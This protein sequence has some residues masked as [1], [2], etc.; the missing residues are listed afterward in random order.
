M[1]FCVFSQNDLAL[2]LVVKNDLNVSFTKEIDFFAAKKN[3]PIKQRY[4]VTGRK[5]LIWGAS[6]ISGAIWGAREAFHADPYVFER[7]FGVEPYSFWGSQ[8]WQRNYEG[9]RYM[10]ENGVPNKHKPEWAGN[11]G[12]DFWHT[13]GYSS[14]LLMIGGT[15]AIGGSKQSFKHKILD[16][17]ISSLCWII[18]S[19]GTDKILRKKS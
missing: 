6:G 2:G 13:S 7:H 12:R 11:L 18:A 8:Q 10:G 14:A 15:F 1:C 3:T 5:I 17:G 4:K 19:N 16:M 9:N